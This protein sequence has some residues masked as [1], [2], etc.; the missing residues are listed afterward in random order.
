MQ[1]LEKPKGLGSSTSTIKYQ[2]TSDEGKRY[3]K[4]LC[5]DG[6]LYIISAEY[7]HIKTKKGE[8]IKLKLNTCQRKVFLKVLELMNKNVPIRIWLLKF[9]QGGLSTLIEAIIYSLTSQQ[10]NRNS[11]IMADLEKKSKNLFE[12]SKLYH[13]KLEESRPWLTPDL[14]KSNAKILEFEDIHSQIIID[15]AKN[16]DAARSFTYQYVHLSECAF[17]GRLK[18]VLDALN[19]SVPDHPDTMIFGETTANLTG[20]FYN[21]WLRAIEGKTDWV[22]IFLPWFWME[23]Y[24]MPLQNGKLYPIKGITF[25]ADI[26]ADVFLKEEI[27]LQSEFKLTN[28]QINWRRWCIVNKCQ[29]DQLRFK[30]EYPATWQEAFS[31]SGTMYFNRRGLENQ[32][33]IRPKRIGDLF[34]QDMKW[35]FRDMPGGK[36]QVFE[37]PDEG[38]QYIVTGDA[39]EGLGTDESGVIHDDASAFVGNKRTNTTCAIVAGQHTPEELAAIM[40]ALGNWYNNAL[41]APENKGYGHMVNQ[42]VYKKYGNVY[43]YKATAKGEDQSKYLGYLTST[44]TRPR[45][46]AQMNEEI[47]NN[48]TELKSAMLVSQCRTFVTKRDKDGQIKKVEAHRSCQDGLVICRA[49]FSDVRNQHPYKVATKSKTKHLQSTRANELKK[50]PYAF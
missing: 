31:L 48:T 9:R 30:T 35:E 20:E 50:K 21:E 32:E 34:Y 28:E 14:K 38:E 7:L 16:V 12:M 13:E 4:A 2:P 10:P 49:I 8:L 44:V 41:V 15:T 25:D 46:L 24:I 1:T 33:E 37:E 23:E 45:M 36:I 11:L 40:I 6:P 17:F 3:D 47:K 5:Q 27:E 29:G 39:S 42:L 18:D 22:P 26:S 19:Q 43:K